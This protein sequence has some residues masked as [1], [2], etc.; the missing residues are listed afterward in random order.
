MLVGMHSTVMLMRDDQVIIEGKVSK[1]HDLILPADLDDPDKQG[2]YR[3][4]QQVKGNVKKLHDTHDDLDERLRE[5]ERIENTREAV[6]QVTQESV[7][8][9]QSKGDQGFWAGVV[10]AIGA[11]AALLKS[12]HGGAS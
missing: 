3:D 6:A 8:A 7:Q 2:M 12:F 4:L 11:A 9:A 10:A 5:Q 1:L